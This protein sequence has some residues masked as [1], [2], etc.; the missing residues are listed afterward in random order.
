MK[1]AITGTGF[2][3][4]THTEALRRAGVDVH[5]ILGSSPEK[6]TLA[7]KRWHISHAY[8]SLDELLHDDAIEVVHITTPNRLHFETAKAALDAGKHVLCEKPLAMNGDESAA[9]VELATKTGRAAAVN[10]NMR[11]YPLCQETKQRIA[12]GDLGAIHSIT[13]SY[14][15]DWLLYDTDYNWRV[16]ASEGG[17]LRAIADI[18][19]H[20]LDLVQDLTQQPVTEVMADL[21]TVHPIRK[22][23]QGEV[24]T[25]SG[26]SAPPESLQPT[27]IETEDMG[28]ILLRF[29]NGARGCLFVS[30]VMAGKKNCLRFELSGAQQTL[31]WN[32][33]SPNQLEI[34]HRSRP[35]EVLA[36]DPGLMTAPSQRYA[37]YPGGHA[38]GYPDSFKM[39]FRA[40]YDYLDKAD[41]SAPCPFPSFAD[42]HREILL[43]DAILNSHQTQTWVRL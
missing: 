13:G 43:C 27:P 20:W 24:E 37:D 12:R 28:C 25:F 42:G 19:T 15:Q 29:G 36:K 2:M 31:A 23:P 7:A 35:N 41:L 32:S 4:G 16:L 22:R 8:Q 5:G 17:A 14:V 33:E 38:E 39:C 1:A 10:Y 30:Q 6:S 18:G 9:L 11:F 40:F 34:G 26:G 21:H 3:G